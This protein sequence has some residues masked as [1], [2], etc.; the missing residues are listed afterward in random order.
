METTITGTG[1]ALLGSAATTAG[2]FGVLTLAVL[3][4][5]QEFGLITALT[6]IFAFLASILV[7]PS[8][9]ALW[10]RY[11]GPDWAQTELRAASSVGGSPEER[12]S[13][14][15]VN[16]GQ[17][18]NEDR[19]DSA[20]LVP[21]EET[22]VS[23]TFERS[24]EQMYV[25]PGQETQVEVT[26]A[27]LHGRLLLREQCNGAAIKNVEVTPSSAA[28]Q[29]GVQDQILHVA[30]D[31]EVGAEENNP[32]TVRYEVEIPAEATDG[33]V[34][35]FSGVVMT[36]TGDL[37]IEGEEQVIVVEDVFERVLAQNTVTRGDLE[38][39]YN[40]FKERD[41]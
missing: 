32:V 20:I 8:L 15:T 35:T 31:T 29:V 4:F 16:G 13:L 25:R 28:L 23:G 6:I 12:A 37:D 26:V 30:L 40:Q 21:S 27:A 5:L 33:D 38:V 19:T 18:V 34:F 7:L 24:L 22:T 10:T 41:L 11:F 36:P 2:G 3:P 1:G 14:D 17:I 9:L 39:A